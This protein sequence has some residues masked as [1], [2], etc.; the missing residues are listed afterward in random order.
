M[1]KRAQNIT[2]MVVKQ[3]SYRLLLLSF[4]LCLYFTDLRKVVLSFFRVK[5]MFHFLVSQAER[6]NDFIV[7]VGMMLRGM[8]FDNYT[9]LYVAAG[10]IYKAE[11]YMT[12][13][14]QMFPRLESKDTLATTEELA[15]FEVQ[16]C[17]SFCLMK[18]ADSIRIVSC[19]N[20]WFRDTHLGWQHL[21]IQSV[22]IVKL[23]S[24]L[25][26]ATSLTSQ[27]VTEDICMKDMQ[28][29]SN[30]IKGNWL[31]CLTAQISG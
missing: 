3:A 29:Q 6:F 14:K 9:S 23:L 15:P 31:F 17:G 1:A 25:R 26:V 19:I 5:D 28:R 2:I 7:Q 21:I 22:F 30:L 13:L 8:G 16:L 24:Q 12:P 27:W 10:K 11:K 18:Q 20:F 4:P